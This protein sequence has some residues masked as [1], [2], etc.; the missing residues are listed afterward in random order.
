MRTPRQILLETARIA[1]LRGFEVVHGIVDSLW[2]K[3][4]G[5]AQK[6]FE[7]LCGEIQHRIGLPVAFEGVYRWIAFLPSRVHEDV[8][9]LN[10]Y[11][12]I[13]EDGSMKVRGIE[14]RRRD[15]IKVVTD[16]QD[17]LLR[18]LSR[19]DDL[20]EAKRLLPEAVQTVRKY[21]ERIRCGDVSLPDLVI[22]NA[23]SK[24]H[25]QYNSN[26]AHV[27]AIRQLA[28]EGL[29]LMAGQ[30]VSYVVTDY[31]SR[32]QGDRVKPVELLDPGT[33]YDREVRGAPA[34]GSSIHTPAIWDRRASPEGEP[35]PRR[36]TGAAIFSGRLGRSN[37][38][39]G[40]GMETDGR[41]LS[42]GTR[43]TDRV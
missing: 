16:C 3:K 14:L 24:D 2:V 28:E 35:P 30:S 43:A 12:G 33:G 21:L 15:S 18:L 27:S 7:E 25:D 10:R 5:A 13:F 42:D 9:V 26:L 39:Q 41:P 37:G 34:E 32:V 19:G 20:E 23:L 8:P 40:M 36:V 38:Q 31:R 17:E 11:F 4:R 29:E 6:D 1:E 22:L